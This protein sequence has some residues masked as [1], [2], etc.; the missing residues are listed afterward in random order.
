[1]V[2]ALRPDGCSCV[3]T[4]VTCHLLFGMQRCWEGSSCRGYRLPLILRHPEEVVVAGFLKTAAG[5]ILLAYLDQRVDQRQQQGPLPP[6]LVGK[7][8]D[9]AIAL[10]FPL[11][12]VQQRPL[13]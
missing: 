2:R 5:D 12:L 1:M 7:L 13:M 6:A 10:H 4:Q 3:M 9:V 11:C 8:S